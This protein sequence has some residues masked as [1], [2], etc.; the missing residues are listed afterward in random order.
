MEEPRAKGLPK[1]IFVTIKVKN[2]VEQNTH[3]VFK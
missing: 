3:N 2:I 1:F